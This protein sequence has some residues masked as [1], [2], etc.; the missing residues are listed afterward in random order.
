MRPSEMIIS[1]H[2]R[3]SFLPIMYDDRSFRVC[4]RLRQAVISLA[5]EK[6]TLADNFTRMH[7]YEPLFL[8]RLY[9]FHAMLFLI[10]RYNFSFLLIQNKFSAASRILWPEDSEYYR[11]FYFSSATDI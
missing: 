7:I 4:C 8:P 10:S 6:E 11:P 2:S 9:F 5:V 3:D 1:F